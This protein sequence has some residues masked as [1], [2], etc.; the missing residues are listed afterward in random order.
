MKIYQITIGRILLLLLAVIA[1]FIATSFYEQNILIT[2]LINGLL[3]TGLAIVVRAGR[4]SLAQATF[5]GIGG[6]T[7]G[8][9]GLNYGLD[10]W[11]ATLVGAAVAAAFGV[12]LGI[13]SIRLKGFY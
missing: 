7:A 9:L 13:T 12:V 6:Y 3:A 8:I 10:F 5:G 11:T 1:P 2:M 4:L